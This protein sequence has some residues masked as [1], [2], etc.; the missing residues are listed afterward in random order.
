MDNVKTGD[1]FRT[2]CCYDLMTMVLKL[3]FACLLLSLGRFLFIFLISTMSLA[4]LCGLRVLKHGCVTEFSMD[5]LHAA[6]CTL[7]KLFQCPNLVFLLSWL[8]RYIVRSLISSTNPIASQ[9][10]D[11]RGMR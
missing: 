10:G 2:L 7:H 8:I 9:K 5:A 4:H 1:M 3:G 6:D 11:A